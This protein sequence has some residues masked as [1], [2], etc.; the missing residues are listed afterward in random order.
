MLQWY[1]YEII[2]FVQCYIRIKM[3][4]TNSIN[5]DIN[6]CW[7]TSHLL[8][9]YTLFNIDWLVLQKCFNRRILRHI[10]FIL[11]Y[12]THSIVFS[13]YI[14]LFTLY[15]IYFIQSILY[16]HFIDYVH[17]IFQYI[18]SFFTVHRYIPF[19]IVHTHLFY[20]TYNPF[21]TVHT[22]H[23]LKVHTL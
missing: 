2:L 16:I 9:Q 13:V 3:W 1:H 15:T 23:F 14:P 7:F 17:S 22:F 5:V 8:R 4:R 19:F 6:I 10:Y 21:F 20:S 11:V 18:H 12:H